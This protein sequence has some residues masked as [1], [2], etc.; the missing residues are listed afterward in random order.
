MNIT[1]SSD[2]GSAFIRHRSLVL[3]DLITSNIF[4]CRVHY[5]TPVMQFSPSYFLPQESKYFQRPVLK[6]SQSVLFLCLENPSFTF[7]IFLKDT[8]GRPNECTRTCDDVTLI[9][10]KN[11]EKSL[12]EN[13][14]A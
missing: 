10:K 1:F 12:K 7:I 2:S 8:I 9:L 4:L 13:L 11:L 14:L 3:L 6:Y 5:G